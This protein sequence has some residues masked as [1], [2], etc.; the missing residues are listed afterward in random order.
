MH[1]H[2]FLEKDQNPKLYDTDATSKAEDSLY[3]WAKDDST[4]RYRHQ[5][6]YQPEGQWCNEVAGIRG[7]STEQLSSLCRNIPEKIMHELVDHWLTINELRGGFSEMEISSYLDLSNNASEFTIKA[8][9]EWARRR[10][11]T[12]E[13]DDEKRSL[14]QIRA[15]QRAAALNAVFEQIMADPKIGDRWHDEYMCHQ[16]EA[17]WTWPITTNPELKVQ[18]R[19]KF[20]ESNGAIPATTDAMRR[21]FPQ[22]R[23]SKLAHIRRSA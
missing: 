15:E 5:P 13:M 8:A 6:A 7:M 16:V 17:E 10:A 2:H 1:H 14:V 20:G 12:T 22:E 4:A 3:V 11:E 9:V 19:W 23:V 21:K 18:T